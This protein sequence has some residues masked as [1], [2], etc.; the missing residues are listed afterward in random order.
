ALELAPGA[1]QAFIEANA[2]DPA[3]RAEV[4]RLL[5]EFHEAGT[6]LSS[7]V[8]EARPDEG[9]KPRQRFKEGDLLASR[10]RV[11]RFIASGGMGEVYEANDL[12]LHE[13]LAIK[14][15]RRE[16]LREPNAVARFKREVQLAR[17]VTHPNVCRIFDIFRSTFP[18]TDSDEEIVFVSMEFLSGETLAERLSRQHRMPITEA[19][20]FIQQMASALAAAHDAGITHRDFKPGNVVLVREAGQECWRAVVTDFGLAL[21]SVTSDETVSFFTGHGLLGTPAYMSPEQ[22]EGRAVAAASDI[23]A[24]GLVIYE[25]LTG[26]RPFR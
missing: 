26:R 3:I 13:R 24:L 7:P 14:T 2:A 8:L 11:V 19:L 16:A 15:I 6:F 22:I 17:K 18:A 21:R 10:F 5:A 9:P 23:Y 1:R 4:G 25:M 20:P 12:E